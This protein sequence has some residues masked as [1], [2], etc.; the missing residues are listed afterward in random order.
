MTRALIVGAFIC[1]ILGCEE[2]KAMRA[3][4]EQAGGGEAEKKVLREAGEAP[5][6]TER[7]II[8]TAKVELHVANLEEA[9]DKLDALLVEVKGYVSK[10]DESGRS[11]TL[12]SG[13]WKVRVPVAKY[14]DFLARVQTFGEL[15]SKTSDAQDVTEEFVDTEARLKNLKAEEAVLNKLLQ[16]KAQNTADLL[17]FRQQITSVR[18]QIERYEAR[19]KT[20]SRLT[21]LTTIDVIMR[22][23][24]KFVP[25]S[26]PSFGTSLGRTF[27][28]S[29]DA[30][31]NLG[32]GLV[33]LL[34]AIAPWSPLILI[35]LWLIRKPVRAV[36][37]N[38]RESFKPVPPRPRST[39]SRPRPT[40]EPPPPPSEPPPV[41][42]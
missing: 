30:L 32:K 42:S 35:G 6:E 34:V 19:L 5:I 40:S 15:I 4:V 2:K 37:T 18:E 13:T 10:S 27:S 31:L 41:P 9:R 20:L 12:R 28:D 25:D 23:D 21:S 39:S 7:K 8:Y 14:H 16:E 3:Q 33:H 38:L 17:A 1:A 36:V 26:A 11:G 24:K 29:V 22:E